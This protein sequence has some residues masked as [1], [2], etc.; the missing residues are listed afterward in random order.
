MPAI[1]AACAA[2]CYGK[3]RRKVA[4]A[5][6]SPLGFLPFTSKAIPPSEGTLSRKK[7]KPTYVVVGYR[8]AANFAVI[9]TL[10]TS[11]S[12]RCRQVVCS[13]PGGSPLFSG[14]RTTRQNLGV[15]S[16]AATQ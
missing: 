13:V 16:R 12:T 8:A 4:F 14:A 11:Q 7:K 6:Y 9:A 5:K 15:S 1:A 3:F 10:T 2:Q